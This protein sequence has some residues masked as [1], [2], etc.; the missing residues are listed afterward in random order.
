MSAF[1]TSETLQLGPL[2][3]AKRKFAAISELRLLTLCRP[4]LSWQQLLSQQSVPP[5]CHAPHLSS[6]GADRYVSAWLEDSYQT[7]RV[8][9]DNVT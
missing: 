4:T 1:G 2:A 7:G 8:P 6:D 5:A 9:P 3:A